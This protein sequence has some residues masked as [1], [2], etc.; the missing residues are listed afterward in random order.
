MEHIENRLKTNLE[1]IKILEQYIIS[2]PELRF[3]Q[4]LCALGLDSSRNYVSQTPFF[5][6]ESEDTLKL[7]KDK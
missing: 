6:E 2:N 1:I 5:Y 4:A 7:L 3:N